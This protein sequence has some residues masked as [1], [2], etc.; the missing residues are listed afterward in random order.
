M[1]RETIY[2]ATLDHFLGPL[3]P[4]MN[5]PRISEIMVM[6]PSTV[7]IE[8]GG[9]IETTALAFPDEAWLEAAVRNV[10]E[11][12]GRPLGPANPTLD[13]RLPD[14]SRVHVI[15]PPASRAG[16][17]LTIRR[18]LPATFDLPTLV[19]DGSICAEAAELLAL[20]VA[21]HQNILISGGTGTGKTSLLNALSM[22]I[23]AQER[24]LVIEDSSEL[25][26][27]QPHTV[28][29]EA[30]TGNE[31]GIGTL[32]VRELFVNALRMR[33]DRIVV[34]EVR[35][36]EALDMVQAMISGH[37]GSLTTI[38]AN[39]PI[40]AL[41]RLELLCRRA[42]VGLPSD[43]ARAQVLL[44]IN[45]VVQIE[46]LASGKRRISQISEV[47]EP[48]EGKGYGLRPLFVSQVV[49]D[50]KLELTATSMEPKFQAEARARGHEH[51][52]QPLLDA[53]R[54]A[55]P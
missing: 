13:A 10:A 55:R 11:Y 3:A 37:P 38:H 7:Y 50:R 26:L 52:I 14:G 48:A 32:T 49:E 54:N 30:Q 9:Q 33:P 43:V 16:I 31:D 47:T 36:S 40:S 42:E 6:G 39:D 34:G 27:H 28:C 44:A 8:R 17:I 20:A 25:R 22:A 24:I 53:L 51:S 15:L 29:L 19:K 45:L 18:F 23:P 21:S 35:Q 1:D 46:R 4:A 5:D 12:V 2:K 41:L